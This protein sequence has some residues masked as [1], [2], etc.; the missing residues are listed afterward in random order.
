MR[1]LISIEVWK[2]QHAKVSCILLEMSSEQKFTN[3][4]SQSE[5]GLWRIRPSIRSDPLQPGRRKR[6]MQKHPSSSLITRGHAGKGPMTYNDISPNNSPPL[7]RNAFKHRRLLYLYEVQGTR[8]TSCNPVTPFSR[9]TLP[10]STLSR[11]VSKPA[12]TEHMIAKH[13]KTSSETSVSHS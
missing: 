10:T 8:I 3:N 2:L 6:A 9:P 11:S 1:G 12:V 4:S 7:K 5:T 13:R